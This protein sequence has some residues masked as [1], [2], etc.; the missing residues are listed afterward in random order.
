MDMKVHPMHH[1]FADRVCAAI[2]RCRLAY[3]VEWH[4]RE[5]WQELMFADEDQTAKA[6]RDPAVPA[7]RSA[8]GKKK[9]AKH[10]LDDGAPVLDTSWPIFHDRM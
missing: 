8:A 3:Y 7:Q 2:L 9:A 4:V 1:Y 5:V 6:M 10:R